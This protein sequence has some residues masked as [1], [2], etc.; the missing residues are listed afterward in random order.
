MTVKPV[1][2]PTEDSAVAIIG[3]GLIGGSIGAS[4][5]KRHPAI[6]VIGVGRRPER[7]EAAQAAGLIDRGT[8]NLVPVA[9]EADLL[10]FCMPVAQIVHDVRLAAA[11]CRSGSLLTDVGSVKGTIC[12]ELATGLP[13]AVTFVGSHPLAGSEKQGFEFSDAD[14]FQGRSVVV[15]PDESTPPESLFRLVT[16]WE[17]IGATVVSMSADDHD[18]ALAQ[19]SHLPH[20]IAAALSAGLPDI[21]RQLAASGF[22][23]TTRIAA[24]DPD[25][26]VE[27]LLGNAEHLIHCIDFYSE[28]L[29]DFRHAIAEGNATKL[30]KLLDVA[31]TNRIALNE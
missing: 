2:K 18:L 23:D 13:P 10:V 20:V 29:A 9:A 21:N 16:F 25:L 14:L 12:R 4:I 22:R 27:I 3:V 5:K 7:L 26:W 11:H 15:T 28:Q 8:T 30:R 1:A 6:E 19:T 17:S 31:Q 24:G